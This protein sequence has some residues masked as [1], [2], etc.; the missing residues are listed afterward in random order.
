AALGS[1]A[2]AGKAARR[3]LKTEQASRIFA[4]DL[5]L[6]PRAQVLAR[7]NR[8]DGVRILGIEMRIVARHED[9]VLPEL[10][11]RPLEVALVGFAGDVAVA[12]D[13]FGGGHLEMR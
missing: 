1:T 6:L 4:Q 11:D 7:A 10:G 3:R 2:A 9:P 13:V 12:P 8:R 5:V